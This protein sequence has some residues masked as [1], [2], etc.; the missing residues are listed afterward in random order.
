MLITETS[1]LMPGP[2]GLL[3]TSVQ[4]LPDSTDYIGVICH[5]HPLYGGT[6]NNKVV[7]TLARTFKDLN[8]D[9]IR[10]NYRGVGQSEGKYDHGNGE[11]DDALFLIEWVRQ[12]YPHKKIWLAGF[13][14]GAYVSL[15]ASVQTP[16]RQL[17]SIAPAVNHADFSGLH[18]H[19]PWLVVI[20]E[21]DAVVPAIDI[22]QWVNTLQPAPEVLSFSDA[23][24]FFDGQLISLRECLREKL[25]YAHT[26]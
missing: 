11:T 25:L 20:A 22:R 6:M 16:V 23:S 1:I 21:K 15:R 9:C 2:A 7:T 10:F 26:L 8:M 12:Q 13:S 3:E 19:C 14:F 4:I 24:H 5:P 18:P 17:I